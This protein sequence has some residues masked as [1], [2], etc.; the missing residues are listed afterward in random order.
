[1]I[2]TQT[3]KIKRW[4]EKKNEAQIYCRELGRTPSASL[5]SHPCLSRLH[6]VV[7]NSGCGTWSRTVTKTDK[8]AMKWRVPCV[9]V[10]TMVQRKQTHNMNNEH[11]QTKNTGRQSGVEGTK[12]KAQFVIAIASKFRAFERHIIKF[13]KWWIGPMNILC[14]LSPFWLIL[15]LLLIF[16]GV[17][18]FFH[19]WG[20]VSI[21]TMC[22]WEYF[23]WA[24]NLI[25]SELA[26]IPHIEISVW[27]NA[28]ERCAKHNKKSA[29]N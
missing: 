28:G 9:C 23:L 1:M 11:S 26:G 15:L 5:V 22:V 8:T 7:G 10:E 12:T 20:F 18:L 25:W 3:R 6:Y 17:F 27:M 24:W 29:V 16:H 21:A 2:S 13:R 19:S 14:L 4:D